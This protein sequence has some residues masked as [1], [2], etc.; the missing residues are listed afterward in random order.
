MPVILPVGIVAILCGNMVVC[1]KFLRP[2]L[3]SKTRKHYEIKT[4]GEDKLNSIKNFI[5]ITLNTGKHP[6]KN[7]K[8]FQMSRTNIMT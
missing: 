6:N 8:W 5:S 4:L 1:V 2:T 7:L 3:M